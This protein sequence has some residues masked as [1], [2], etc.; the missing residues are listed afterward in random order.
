MIFLIR[1]RGGIS[2]KRLG[3]SDEAPVKH[4]SACL[5]NCF[6]KGRGATYQIIQTNNTVMEP[7][8]HKMRRRSVCIFRIDSDVHIGLPLSTQN[9]ARVARKRGL[10]ESNIRYS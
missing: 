5:K 9:R 4:T 8:G 1:R 10:H 3:K 7:A 2:L 6:L